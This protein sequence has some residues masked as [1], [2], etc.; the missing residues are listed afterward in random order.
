MT[1][2]G[3]E[4]QRGLPADRPGERVVG[5]GVAGVQRQDDVRP[6]VQLGALRWSRRRTAG[7]PASRAPST[8]R[9]FRFRAAGLWSIPVIR[10][11]C[12]A[13]VSRWYAASVRY[14][15]PQPRSTTCS[16]RP[17]AIRPAATASSSAGASSLQNSSIC[18]YFDCRDGF[19]R[20]VVVADPELDQERRRRIE[21]PLLHPVVPGLLLPAVAP[22]GAAAPC[23]SWCSAA[24][25]SRSSSRRASSRTARS[26]SS[27]RPPPPRP[28]PPRSGCAPGARRTR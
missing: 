15:F 28:R 17:A 4:H 7:G 5:R 13:A 24:A 26:S 8:T 3:R 23:P 25:A 10:T 16:G 12:P 22:A 18:L 27:S 14:A 19:T 1:A 11:S 21:H 6:G 2:W 20:P 9:V